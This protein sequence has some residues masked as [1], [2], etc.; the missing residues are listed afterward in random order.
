MVRTGTILL[1][2]IIR[3]LDLLNEVQYGFVRLI[4]MTRHTV[5][6]M[7]KMNVVD[8]ILTCVIGASVGRLIV[9]KEDGVQVALSILAR[10]RY[11]ENI[12]TIA[13]TRVR[14]FRL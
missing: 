8:Q 11:S 13:W 9:D 12:C 6:T 4:C 1:T 5:W 3:L 10:T 7:Y 14:I 2:I